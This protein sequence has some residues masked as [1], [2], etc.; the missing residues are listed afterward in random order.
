MFQFVLVVGAI[1]ALY[2]AWRCV[3]VMDNVAKAAKKSARAALKQATQAEQNHFAETIDRLVA[4]D[5]KGNPKLEIRLGTIYELELIA[6]NSARNHWTAMEVLTAYVRE[7]SPWQ[8][9]L[10]SDQ[11]AENRAARLA[12]KNE[13][14]QAIVTAVL[15]RRERHITDI[16]AILTIL[17][18]RIRSEK[19]ENDYDNRLDL[20]GTDLRGAKLKEAHLDR[21]KFRGAHLEEAELTWAHLEWADLNGVQLDAAD[22]EKAHLNGALLS[23]ASLEAA[24][25][26]EASLKR[27]S[28]GCTNL[29]QADLQEAHLEQAWLVE[30][31]L[32]RANL[33][34][35]HLNEA[36]LSGADLRG[37]TLDEAHLDGAFI[38]TTR[39]DGVDLGTVKG[40][41]Q[42][43]LNEASGDKT[44]KLPERLQHPEHWLME[45]DEE[46]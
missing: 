32:S 4:T 28:L 42:K 13:E 3:R 30:A 15:G 10:G 12:D 26:S 14:Q 43:Q 6:K 40:L 18:R 38:Y 34:G 33:T 7:N 8:Q 35:A 46:E 23:G 29:Y 21:A 17:S 1:M 9:Q 22:L 39:L 19:R 36:H 25:L 11:A 37:A 31:K 5:D 20:S 24:K 2:L 45:S 27:A 16:Q 41:T 44:T